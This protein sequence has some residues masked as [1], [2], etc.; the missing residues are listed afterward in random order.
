MALVYAKSTASVTNEHGVIY[1]VE[2]NQ[3]WD[4]DDPLVKQHPDLF[5]SLPPGTRTSTGW[6]ETATAAPGEKRNVKR[7]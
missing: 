2:I 4:A 6:V 5:S 3:P 7:G 1:R